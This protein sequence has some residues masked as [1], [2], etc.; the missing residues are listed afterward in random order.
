MAKSFLFI[1]SSLRKYLYKSFYELKIHFS[2][3]EIVLTWQQPEQKL[4]LAVS[5]AVRKII[6]VHH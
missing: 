5:K 6:G 4:N 2:A 1:Y 3:I